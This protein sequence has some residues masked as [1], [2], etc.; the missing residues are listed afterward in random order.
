MLVALLPGLPAMLRAAGAAALAPAFTGMPTGLRAAI[1]LGA[2]CVAW[3]LGAGGAV[4]EGAWWQ[5]APM[6]LLAGVCIGAIAAASVEALRLAGRIAGEQMG[7]GF[8]QSYLPAS[9][10]EAIGAAEN[11][12]GW[13]G[14]AAFVAVG[15]IEGV[16]IAAARSV[17][18]DGRAWL[19]SGE[20]IAGTLDAAM[21]VGLRVCLPLLAVTLAGAGIAGVMVRVAPR[22]MTV[23]GG[24]GVRAAMGLGMLAASAAAAWG[25]QGTFVRSMLDRLSTGAIG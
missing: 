10:G 6:E 2:A 12:M 15:G 14:A 23:G 19:A 4:P 21:Q 25:L 17:P 9:D 22:L 16:V 7:L 18:G 13:A 3:P 20:G 11:A 5:W 8:G 1:A 24:F